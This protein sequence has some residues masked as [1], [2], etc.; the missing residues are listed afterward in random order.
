MVVPP[1]APPPAPSTTAMLTAHAGMSYRKFTVPS[2]GSTTQSRPLVPMCVASSSPTIPSSGRASRISE[3]MSVSVSRSTAVTMSTG[4][5][6]VATTLTPARRASSANS[7]AR[8]AMSRARSSRAADA[9]GCGELAHAHHATPRADR[10]SPD[11]TPRRP[12]IRDI[13]DVRDPGND[14]SPG[15]PGLST[16]RVRD[17]N[18]RS[19]RQLIYSQIPLA[20]WVTRQSH[21][22]TF[23]TQPGACQGYPR[24]G[25]ARNQRQRADVAASAA[26]S[27][28]RSQGRAAGHARRGM[29]ARAQPSWRHQGTSIGAVCVCSGS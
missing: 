25:V 15:S 19:R 17:S 16:W 29:R 14:E 1:I 4:V 13:R 10:G 11:V 22:T 24:S 21:P 6:L 20:A 27:S 23:C 2:I 18:P 5:D 8:T 12:D 3:R 9:G 28:R 7:A 26:P